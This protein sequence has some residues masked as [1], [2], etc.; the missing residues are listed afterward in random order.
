VASALGTL[1]K[2]MK[3]LALKLGG[4]GFLTYPLLERS[5]GTPNMPQ[6]G[7]LTT[8]FD[9]CLQPKALSFRIRKSFSVTSSNNIVFGKQKMGPLPT[10]GRNVGKKL[11]A[12]KGNITFHP[13]EILG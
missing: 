8:L 1:P 2:E 6:Y 11:Q 13:K 4:T 5:Y 9:S 10:F 7:T 3:I 12:W